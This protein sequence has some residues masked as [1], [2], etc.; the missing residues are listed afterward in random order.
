MITSS[1]Q[2]PQRLNSKV[3]SQLCGLGKGGCSFLR[4]TR[5][6]NKESGGEP[7]AGGSHRTRLSQVLPVGGENGTCPKALAATSRPGQARRPPLGKS[8]VSSRDPKDS[9]FPGEEGLCP[10]CVVRAA[11]PRAKPVKPRRASQNRSLR[12][13]LPP[14]APGL[15]PSLHLPQ[16]AG[17]APHPSRVPAALPLPVEAAS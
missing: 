4:K 10:N 6:P 12:A 3:D 13:P 1:S 14:P 17:R 2:K 15:S 8:P 5:P 9:C 7:T 16:P 11:R